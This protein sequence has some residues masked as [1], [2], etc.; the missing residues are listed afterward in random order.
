MI[1]HERV[2]PHYV[3]SSYNRPRLVEIACS[4]LTDLRE[5]KPRG[6]QPRAGSTWTGT[7]TVEE[8]DEKVRY[9]WPKLERRMLGM[10]REV[11]FEEGALH[12][13]T[14]IKRRRTRRDLGN[15][16]DIHRVYQGQLEQAWDATVRQEDD[17][18]G[19]KIVN[20]VVNIDANGWVTFE[21]SLWR[22]AVVMRLYEAL[23]NM[24]KSVAVTVYDFAVGGFRERG[25]YSNINS[26]SSCRVKAHGEQLLSDKLASM[27]NVGF[28]RRYFM[29]HV[30]RSHP[31][32]EV[33]S[34]HGRATND[35]RVIHKAAEDD[36][37]KGGSVIVI[38]HCFSKS[39]CDKVL[40]QFVR[41]YVR[42]E[43][44]T[45]PTASDFRLVRG[46]EE[47]APTAQRSEV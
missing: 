10:L 30:Q 47:I 9:G 38:G 11:H 5:C 45:N 44:P 16:I 3:G 23:S 42:G 18:Y 26:M 8:F 46:I 39:E 36:L 12:Q 43:Q 40:D 17:A 31:E 32:L 41:Q 13:E 6:A 4:D 7:G 24:G 20:L 25:A 21:D 28:M 35:Y 1:V 37:K 22:G 2:I 33:G 14:V 27:V 15:E 29:E 19:S 34:G